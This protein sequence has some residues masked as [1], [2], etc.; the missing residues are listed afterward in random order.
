[1]NR[2][3]PTSIAGTTPIGSD[4]PLGLTNAPAIIGRPRTGWGRS[5]IERRI[6]PETGRMPLMITGRG[7][8]G[9]ARA[10]AGGAGRGGGGG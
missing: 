4:E 10:L 2:Q 9:L 1:M 3:R 7:G 5:M 8:A 6:R